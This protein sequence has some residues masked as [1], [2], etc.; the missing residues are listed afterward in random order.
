MWTP[1]RFETVKPTFDGVLYRENGGRGIPPK[2]DIYLPPGP[3]P[4]PSVIL[5]HGGAYLVGSRNMKPMR[6]LASELVKAGFV[7]ASM[8]YRMV[9]RGGRFTEGV[10]DVEAMMDWWVGQTKAY[11]LDPK[12]I[13]IL[14]VS[15]GSAL[16]LMALERRPHQDIARI[17]SVYGV[18]DFVNL[19]G[20][21]LRLLRRALFRSNDPALWNQYSPLTSFKGPQPILFLHG[22][23]DGIV[24]IE[25][26]Y[27]LH[28]RR[29]NED[30]PTRLEVSE[31]SPH[32]FFND[33]SSSAAR[34]NITHLM[35]FLHADLERGA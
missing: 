1:D 32:G 25:Q 6:F 34:T 24:P 19:G 20:G 31:G 5:V 29:L 28:K 9:L 26:A 4:H 17:V 3:G 27:A 23:N 11:E 7:V 2:V 8:D 22:T 12:N 18:Y 33:A 30:Y 15:A 21:L 16:T 14:G 13:S 35:E 10:D